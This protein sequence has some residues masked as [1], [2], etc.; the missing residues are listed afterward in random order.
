MF[1][2]AL[3]YPGIVASIAETLRGLRVLGQNEA[4]GVGTS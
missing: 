1:P 3:P 2:S 4:W